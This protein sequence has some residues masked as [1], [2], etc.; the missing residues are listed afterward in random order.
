MQVTINQPLSIRLKAPSGMAVDANLTELHGHCIA[1]EGRCTEATDRMVQAAFQVFGEAT[2]PAERD[3]LRPI[4]RPASYVESL[5]APHAQRSLPPP[6]AKPYV[7]ELWIVLAISRTALISMATTETLKQLGLNEDSA[8]DVA[9]ANVTQAKPPVWSAHPMRGSAS[10]SW[11]KRLDRPLAAA[12]QW[13]E[14]AKV[15]GGI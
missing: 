15:R 2:R 10:S 7:G 12:T 3:D 5:K 14:V 8:F 9:L 4:V 1:V 11:A 13:A 6:I